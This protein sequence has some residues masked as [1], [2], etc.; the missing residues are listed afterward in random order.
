MALLK[1]AAE[2]ADRR[3]MRNHARVVLWSMVLVLSG[4]VSALA[5]NTQVAELGVMFWK[6]TPELRLSTDVLT[7]AGVS[8]VD[9]VQEFGIENKYFPEFRATLGR[10][11]KFR[12]SFVTFDYNAEAIITRR[13]TFR[14][15]TFDVGA[16]AT[17]DISWKLYKFGY[18]FDFVSRP[19]GFFGFIADLKYNRVEA[20]IDSPVLTS[21]A[22]TDV[23]APVPAIGVIGRGY[24]SDNVSITGEFTGLNLNRG[25]DKGKFY[26]FDLYGTVTAGRNFGVQGGYRSVVVDYVVDA[27]TGVL[28]MKG[29]YFGAVVR[30]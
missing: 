23:T 19:G 26:D 7:G 25:E 13:I 1:L 16:P 14:G 21:A 17:A 12:T 10:T 5:Q 9:F 2:G 15:Q 4:S 11:H 18:E 27:D 30:F 29:L 20:S 28:K 3:D 8:E 22:T 24:L 6:P